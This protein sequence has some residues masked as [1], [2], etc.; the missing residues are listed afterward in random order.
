[1]S[2]LEH[3]TCILTLDMW[4]P[5]W[6]TREVFGSC[7]GHPVFLLGHPVTRVKGLKCPSPYHI[8]INSNSS[9]RV[10]ILCSS[11]LASSFLFGFLLLLCSSS[12]FLLPLLV[13]IASSS[14]KFFCSWFFFLFVRCC[15]F[16]LCV[17]SPSR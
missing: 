9:V 13:P 16:F 2:L 4:P 1:M 10:T 17:A 7:L 3:G 12:S 5:I 8:K 11:S 6:V 14:V 15:F